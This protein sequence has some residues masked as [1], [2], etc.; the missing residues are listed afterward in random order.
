MRKNTMSFAVGVLTGA[1]LFGGGVAYAAGILAEPSWQNIYVDGKQVAMTAYNIGGSNYVK[2]R[3][4][5]QAVGFNVYWDDGVQIDSTAPYTG[6][7]PVAPAVPANNGIQISSYKGSTITVGERSGLIV[8]PSGPAYTVTSSNPT[9]VSVENVMGF[10]TAAAKAPGTATITATAPDG[11]TGRVTITVASAAAQQSP[12]VGKQMDVD[13][14][15]NMEIRLEMIRLINEVRRENGAG[16][17]TVNEALMNA[18]QDCSN[19]GFTTHHNQYECES[20]LAYGYPHGFGSNLTVFTGASTS[21]IAR[22]AVNNWVNSSGHFQTI[23]K[24]RYECIG[25]GVTIGKTK[26]CCYMFVGD[27]NSY[28]PY[29]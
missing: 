19:Q 17:L 8:G 1:M 5:G 15:A 25:V 2:L 23:I 29:G 18:A 26:T 10:W 28:N 6:E 21:E 12:E 22:R 16:E 9:V 13:L 24:Q 27:P 20:G 4:I 11:R 14:S 7:A 3:D